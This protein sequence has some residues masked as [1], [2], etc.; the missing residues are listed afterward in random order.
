MLKNS[1]QSAD[2]SS[3]CLTVNVD[4]VQVNCTNGATDVICGVT[5]SR[6]G[7]GTDAI[8][9]VKL[10]FK[11]TTSGVSSTSTIDVAG[12]IEALVT[13]RVNSVDT[14]VT[15]ANRVSAV[16]VTPYFTDS[17]GNQKLCSQTS[18]FTF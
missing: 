1:G 6:T 9:G 5:L 10:I 13:K 4:A 16:S 3:K 14:L 15:I 12:N 18:T 11:N 8:G 17:S 7:T 2:I